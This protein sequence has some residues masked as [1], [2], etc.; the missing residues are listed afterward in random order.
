MT[1]TNIFAIIVGGK[2]DWIPQNL[3]QYTLPLI[4]CKEK[5]MCLSDIIYLTHIHIDSSYLYIIHNVWCLYTF[6][7]SSL[8]IIAIEG[9]AFYMRWYSSHLCM[10]IWQQP[11]KFT[12]LQGLKLQKVDQ[13]N[14]KGDYMMWL[15]P[16]TCIPCSVG[17]QCG[18]LSIGR[19][20]FIV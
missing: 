15:F 20:L 19:Y 12:Q 1:K 7:I 16:S 4:N 17:C 3:Y 9:G 5:S 6:C 14:S 2:N 13:S 10:M 8:F 11:E 18:F